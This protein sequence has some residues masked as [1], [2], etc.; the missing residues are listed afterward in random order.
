LAPPKFR[1]N[2]H[3]LALYGLCAACAR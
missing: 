2:A 1:V 3:A